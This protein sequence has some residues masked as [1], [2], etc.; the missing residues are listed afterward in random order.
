VKKNVQKEKM[1]KV[2]ITIIEGLRTL[3]YAVECPEKGL[4]KL[5]CAYV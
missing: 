5:S 1:V 2:I 4:R 3:N